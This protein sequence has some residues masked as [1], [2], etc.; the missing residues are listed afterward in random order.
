MGRPF[1]AILN[2]DNS[3]EITDIIDAM[4]TINE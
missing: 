2:G 4:E 1:G 3:N